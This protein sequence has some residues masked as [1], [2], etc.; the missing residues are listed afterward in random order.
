M[1]QVQFLDRV[2]SAPVSTQRQERVQNDAM[3]RIVDL[4]VPQI[5]KETGE[6][7]QLIPHDCDELIPEWLNSV[8]GVIDS[9]DLPLNISHETLQRNKILRVI[10]KNYVTKYL[11]MLA[12]IAELNAAY[13]KLY[14]QFGECM[15]LGISEDSAVGVECS[16]LAWSLIPVSLCSLLW[17]NEVFLSLSLYSMCTQLH[18]PLSSL[19]HV[20]S[21]HV[22]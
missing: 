2:L 16:A 8:K 13:R 7:T 19:S 20:T 5:R 14:E 6:V 21:L 22:R 17:L 4:P 3:E 15:K 11:E 12:E 10:K 9:V 1:P 18:E